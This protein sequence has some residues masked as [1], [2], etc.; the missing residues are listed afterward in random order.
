MMTSQQEEKI[1][2]FFGATSIPDVSRGAPWNK[3]QLANWLIW[4]CSK[5]WACARIKGNMYVDHRYHDTL[6]ESMAYCA[7]T[8][9]SSAL[10]GDIAE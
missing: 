4:H 7:A 3:Y 6:K 5:G 9:L 1:A 2:K 10:A 8:I